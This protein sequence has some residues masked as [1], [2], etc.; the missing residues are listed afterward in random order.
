[1]RQPLPPLPRLP[2]RLAP[3][4]LPLHY[5]TSWLWWA[6]AAYACKHWNSVWPLLKNLPSARPAAL[7]LAGDQLAAAL[8]NPL[9][10]GSVAKQV[11][12]KAA[13]ATEKFLAGINRYQN[14]P[15]GRQPMPSVS[16]WQQGSSNL[17]D[18]GGGAKPLLLV[19][20]LVNRAYILD[21]LP[22]CS[23]VRWL[24]Q[25]GYRPYLLDWGMPGQAELSFTV[26]DYV[27]RAQAALRHLRQPVPV[28]GYCMGGTLAVALAALQPQ[29]VERLMVLAAPW[30]FTAFEAA[31]ADGMAALARRL[32]GGR[33]QSGLLPVDA[34]QIMF[35]ARDPAMVLQK[36]HRF[37]GLASHSPEADL[38]VAVEDWLNDGVPLPLA[39]AREC[40][41][42]WFAGNYPATNQ[43][44]VGR[45]IINPRQLTMPSLLVVP[46]QDKIVPPA[47]AHALARALPAATVLNPDSG[48]IGMITSRQAYAQVWQPLLAWLQRS[49]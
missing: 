18:F 29:R 21:L 34:L 6:T 43:W 22:R 20:S 37:A 13:Q 30:D 4:P 15:T 17:Y 23:V 42:D 28:L 36:F 5:Q 14:Y 16:V 10:R 41:G 11:A 49:N 8:Q 48:H 12:A 2:R 46:K 19:P 27:Q 1:M 24:Q 31:T 45:K 40:F 7:R 26:A 39:V 38:F 9:V 3:R 47:A 32:A 33:E 35:Y 44:R 25:A